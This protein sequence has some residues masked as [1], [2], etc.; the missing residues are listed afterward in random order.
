MAALRP[1]EYKMKTSVF[2][3]T[4]PIGK[5]HGG[6]IVSY[7][8]CQALKEVSDLIQ[9]VCPKSEDLGVPVE[10]ISLND[11]YS[12]NPFMWDYLT[13]LKVKHAD[14]AFFN[15]APFSSTA[16][17]VNPSKL[18]VDVPAHNLELSIE[19]WERWQGK[20]PFK[21]MT[22]P[23]LWSLYTD[24]IV[25]ADVVICPSKMSAD[26]VKQNP[27]TKAKV[28]VIPHGTELP[29]EV[30]PLPEQFKVGYLGATGTDKGTIYLL[31]AWAGLMY[32][33][34]ELLLAGDGW[35]QNT[36][37]DLFHKE[38][39]VKLLGRVENV[40][41]FYNSIS[42]YCQPSV[43]EGFGIP[44]LEAMAHGRAVIVSEGAGVSELIKDGVEGFVVPIRDAGAIAD[45]VDWLKRRPE[46][47]KEM[48]QKARLKAESHTWS[49]TEAEFERLIKDES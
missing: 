29:D 49:K 6:G 31:K 10:T 8:E 13:S 28:V 48:G 43:T 47:V 41:D 5:G 24:F 35:S 32:K 2:C 36:L 1:W 34:S 44:C 22:D 40:S 42:V 27:G 19:E 39:R 23:F 26:Y 25:N 46:K 9:V 33:D 20:Y 4:A 16:R 14:I 18:I 21:H 38:Q 3:T 30:K 11:R 7:Y 45:R 37:Y 12:D 15:G 17:A